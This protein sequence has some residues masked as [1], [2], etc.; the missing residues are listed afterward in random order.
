MK[1]ALMIIAI[2]AIVAIAGSMLYYFVFFRAGI[3]K[4]EIR[5]QEE[6]QS[7][8]ELR[9]ENK[10]AALTAALAVAEIWYNDSVDQAY[11]DYK[12]QWNKECELLGL[13]PDSSLPSATA[14]WLNEYYDKAVERIDEQYQRKKDDIYKIYE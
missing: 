9:I 3:E 11:K 10:K 14:D 4:A 1:K 13:K 2:V 6:K 7:S 5:L 12:D 8:E